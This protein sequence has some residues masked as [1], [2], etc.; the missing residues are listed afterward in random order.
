LL[1]TSLSA[2]PTLLPLRLLLLDAISLFSAAGIDDD[3][4]EPAAPRVAMPPA[5][6]FCRDI[7][8]SRFRE[9]F[10]EST[11]PSVRSPLWNI[12]STRFDIGKRKELPFGAVD[13]VMW[14]E[15]VMAVDETEP[16][17]EALSSSSRPL[18]CCGACKV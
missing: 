18:L 14:A 11:R 13:V 4:D 16:C 12:C 7:V 5:L 17:T 2:G 6:R 1:V 10:C 15:L 8:D 9:L 3:D